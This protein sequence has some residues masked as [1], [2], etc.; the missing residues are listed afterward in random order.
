[1]AP[2]S[3]GRINL[4]DVG[5][6]MGLAKRFQTALEEIEEKMSDPEVKR[7]DHKITIELTFKPLKDKELEGSYRTILS[8]KTT[9]P[10]AEYRGMICHINQTGKLLTDKVSGDYHQPM[11]QN[12]EQADESHPHQN[13]TTPEYVTD[14]QPQEPTHKPEIDPASVGQ[15]LEDKHR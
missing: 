1:M 15:P 12:T 13:N 8:V 11:L 7:G 3:T 6:R 9:S 14:E 2:D 4:D 10:K 5:G